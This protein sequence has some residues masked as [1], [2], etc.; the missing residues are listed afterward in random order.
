[1]DTSDISE[2]ILKI[3][4]SITLIDMQNDKVVLSSLN[5]NNDS[6]I[7]YEEYIENLKK[8]IHPDYS[9]DYF[10]KI[11]VLKQPRKQQK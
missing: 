4:N 6:T 7:T 8:I 2:N 1:M 10:N 5:G 3:F 9:V 11:S